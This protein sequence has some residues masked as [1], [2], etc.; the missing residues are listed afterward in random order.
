MNNPHILKI[1]PRHYE[2]L[3]SVYPLRLD[4][5]CF[6]WP[7]YHIVILCYVILGYI[8]YAG[9]LSCI[10]GCNDVVHASS[11]EI[12]KHHLKQ[13]VFFCVCVYIF[14]F[15]FMFCKSSFHKLLCYWDYPLLYKYPVGIAKKF[16]E[17]QTFCL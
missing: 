9:P 1:N 15:V 16:N 2:K 11:F 5:Q 7:V 17:M 3:R 8:I 10:L 14:F 4:V 6:L 13:H 12:L